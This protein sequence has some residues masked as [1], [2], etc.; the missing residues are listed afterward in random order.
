MAKL[1]MHIVGAPGT[2]AGN[3]VIRVEP[4]PDGNFTVV[5]GE[6]LNGTIKKEAAGGWIFDGTIKFPAK[7]YSVGTPFAT[8]LDAMK[9][10]KLEKGDGGMTTLT[11][12]FKY[13][14]EKP[15]QLETE[16]FPVQFKFDA[17]AD[18]KFVV[19]LMPGL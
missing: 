17:P 14:K 19:L 1:N 7:G 10:A 16:T 5:G 11:V 12:P 18:T 4:G 9:G 6:G 2:G 15:T 13:P 3:A 8:S